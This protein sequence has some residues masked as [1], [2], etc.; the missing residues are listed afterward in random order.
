[1]ILTVIGRFGDEQKRGFELGKLVP[2]LDPEAD[3]G[4]YR[5]FLDL[6]REMKD[7]HG[8]FLALLSLIPRLPPDLLSG[9]WATARALSESVRRAAVL[10]EVARRLEGSDRRDAL[11]EA[12]ESADA[13]DN[14]DVRIDRLGALAPL[15]ACLPAADLGILWRRFLHRSAAR[16]RPCLLRELGALVPGLAALGGGSAV[17]EAFHAAEDVARWWP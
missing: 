3:A 11:V 2:L 9:A 14:L 13:I 17:A 10:T 15:L 16:S 6:A 5:R 12:Y 8:R 1:L 7:E 4:W